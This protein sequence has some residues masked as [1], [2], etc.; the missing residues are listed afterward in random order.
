MIDTDNS[1]GSSGAM[2]IYKIIPSSQLI[3]LSL[4]GTIATIV[5][6]CVVCTESHD[7]DCDID[8]EVCMKYIESVPQ[9]TFDSLFLH[10]TL[11]FGFVIVTDL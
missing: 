1:F 10:R 11:K 7:A 2:A 4:Y 3:N 9:S 5:F 6:D 8:P